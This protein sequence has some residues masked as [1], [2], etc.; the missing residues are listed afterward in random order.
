M[1][2][3]TQLCKQAWFVLL[4]VFAIGWSGV[5]MAS[6]KT[7]Q[8]GMQMQH[9]QD[10]QQNLQNQ[11]NNHPN[12]PL[13][14]AQMMQG[15]SVQEMKNHCTDLQQ[16]AVTDSK[17]NHDESHDLQMQNLK[18]CHAQL[19]QSKQAQ[20]AT[21]QDCSLYSCQSSLVWFNADIP[22]LSPPEHLQNRSVISIAYQAQHLAGHWQEILRPPKA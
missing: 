22:Q 10:S 19:I 16:Q 6:V 18:N 8:M 20:Q 7:M 14:H 13:S 4:M 21:C 3:L 2:M 12:E 5:S 11:S 1:N 15:M 17:Q 9:Q